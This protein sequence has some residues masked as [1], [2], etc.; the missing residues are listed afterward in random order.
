VLRRQASQTGCDLEAAQTVVP[1]HAGTTGQ[2]RLGAVCTLSK[3]SLSQRVA[4]ENPD[5]SLG[6]VSG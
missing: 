1:A 6:F 2:R 3:L 5:K 4:P